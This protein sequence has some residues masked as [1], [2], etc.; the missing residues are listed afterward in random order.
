MVYRMGKMQDRLL[1]N[2]N[3]EHEMLVLLTIQTGAG[4][5]VRRRSQNAKT[6]SY[7]TTILPTEQNGE[8]DA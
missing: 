6:K 5:T 2:D 3:L 7:E 4:W 1:S 8:I